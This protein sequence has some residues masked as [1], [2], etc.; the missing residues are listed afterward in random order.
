MNYIVYWTEDVIESDD[1]MEVQENLRAFSH[2]NDAEFNAF[3]EN[4]HPDQIIF[5]NDIL[6]PNNVP[7]K[8]KAY[9][10]YQEGYGSKMIYEVF[11]ESTVKQF[12][13]RITGV[14]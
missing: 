8:F 9:E 1:E 11:V 12:D 3:K 13:N 4:I 14:A 5:F 7:V 10:E 6:Y 2:H